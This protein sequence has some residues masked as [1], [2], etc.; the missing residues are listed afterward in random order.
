M[1]ECAG[2][3]DSLHE[4]LRAM[5]MFSRINPET[6]CC[7]GYTR[8]SYIPRLTAMFIE[9]ATELKMGIETEKS[10]TIS[11]AH[12]LIQIAYSH[13]LDAG[14]NLLP[15]HFSA[16]FIAFEA[17]QAVNQK[18]PIDSN[19]MRKFIRDLLVKSCVSNF[20]FKLRRYELMNA[21]SEEARTY[22]PWGNK[23]KSIKRYG[24]F[25]KQYSFLWYLAC[26]YQDSSKTRSQTLPPSFIQNEAEKQTITNALNGDNSDEIV[27]NLVQFLRSSHVPESEILSKNLRQ[28]RIMAADIKETLLKE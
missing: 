27:A 3:C 22:L 21:L 14:R 11:V 5:E 16:V 23:L 10:K 4:V 12:T 24:Y 2:F 15:L 7:Q 17:M 18:P 26:S 13:M 19:L 25:N 8:I 9:V 20:T 1:T 28:L 6:E